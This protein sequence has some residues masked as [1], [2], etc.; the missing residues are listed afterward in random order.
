M[1]HKEE[2]NKDGKKIIKGSKVQAK[3]KKVINLAI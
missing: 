3:K 2:D 1:N